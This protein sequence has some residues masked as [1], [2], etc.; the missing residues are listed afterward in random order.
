MYPVISPFCFGSMF[1]QS[2]NCQILN[3]CYVEYAGSS[4][5][6]VLAVEA[7]FAAAAD[8]LSVISLHLVCL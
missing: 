1:F 8:L 5:A 6:Q 3:G 2:C 4:C 7:S